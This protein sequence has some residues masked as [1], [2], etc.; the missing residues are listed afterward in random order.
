MVWSFQPQFQAHYLWPLCAPSVCKCCG[1]FNHKAWL[2]ICGLYM[3]HQR[4]SV[5]VISTTRPGSPFVASL[6]PHQD[7]GGLV[8]STT[9][10]GSPFLASLYPISLYVVW[11]FQPQFQAHYL[12]PL[13]APSVC[14]CCGHFNHKA[15]LTICGLFVP[16]Q[17]VSVVVIST[18]RPGSPFIFFKCAPSACRWLGHLNHK[19][20]LTICGLFVAYQY[21]SGM[22]ISTTRPGSPFVASLCPISM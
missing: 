3:P 4:V 20:W 6:C 7:V 9:R 12:W 22:V 16:H 10:P 21:V 17:D 11:S 15:W 8:I 18:T 5:V 2:T 14:K 19:A 1:H 13:C